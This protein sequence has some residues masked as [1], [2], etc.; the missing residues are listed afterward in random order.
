MPQFALARDA[1]SAMVAGDHARAEVLLRQ[2]LVVPRDAG[3][4]AATA[5]G[6]NGLG[7]RT[8][9][10]GNARHAVT[11]HRN[12]LALYRRLGSEAGV[13]WSLQYLGEAARNRGRL[14]SAGVLQERA[15][16]AFR[17]LADG[18]GMSRALS[19]QGSVARR[20]GDFARARSLY[21]E[22]LLTSVALADQRL[23]AIAVAGIAGTALDIGRPRSAG[24]LFQAVRRLLAG[25]LT[26]LRPER[27]DYARDARRARRSAS[28]ARASSRWRKATTTE[29][30]AWLVAGGPGQHHSPSESAGGGHGDAESPP[31]VAS[32][33]T[34]TGAESQRYHL[35][36]LRAQ[37]ET[38]L[39]GII[40]V[41]T[42]ADIAHMNQRFVQMWGIPSDA[43]SGLVRHRITAR[44]MEQVADPAA[45][46]AR[47]DYLHHHPDEA[48]SAEV[49]LKDRR[50]FEHYSA[51][52]VGGDGTRYGRI[53]YYRDVTERKR[54][55]ER[56]RAQGDALSRQ[57]AA[58]RDARVQ[59]TLREERVR[60]EIAELLH[61]RVQTQLVVAH[62][63]ASRALEQLREDPASAAALL[64][65]L[66]DELDDIRENGVR[67]ASHLLHPTVISLGLLPAL[68]YLQVRFRGALEISLV[69]DRHLA[70]T[71]GDT[72]V[73]VPEGV[74][75]AAYRVVEEALANVSRHAGVSTARVA[76]GLASDTSLEATVSDAGGGF[77]PQEARGGLGFLA[78]GSRVEEHGGT[79]SVQSARGAGT[80]LTARF[81]LNSFA[82]ALERATEFRKTHDAD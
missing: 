21:R 33:S 26:L 27:Q 1:L 50:V 44:I 13:A 40:A 25:R 19:G 66:R 67:R 30:V 47:S 59:A 76:L 20:C 53:G 36:L 63:R 18:A 37:S 79:W 32:R 24:L 45:Y 8:L 56:I 16:N 39:D 34:D 54:A 58:L 2:R 5:A 80:T 17:A 46:L 49:A 55:E 62:H 78:I 65:Q 23:I 3:D 14:W 10:R 12:A 73:T 48:F 75:L 57:V 29:I 52:V 74:A 31:V 64:G 15:L 82:S 7:E 51:P 68:A 69:I 28:S 22:S 43:A 6:L 35:A 9:E 38:S 4:E 60:R 77:D 41:S 81:P 11:L 61:S 42:N 72:G 70:G 71:A